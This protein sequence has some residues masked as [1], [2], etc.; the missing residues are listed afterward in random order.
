MARILLIED[1]GGY[2]ST[3][4]E[5]LKKQGYEVK[6][7]Y[8]YN[9]A[10]GLWRKY[11]GVF[12]CIILDLNI[13]PDG[14]EKNQKEEYSPVHGILVLVKICDGKMPNESEES[15]KIWG[16]TIIHSAYTSNLELKLVK[17]A[18]YMSLTRIPK[19]EDSIS[20]V[21][22]KVNEIIINNSNNG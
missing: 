14:L 11:S 21:I 12:D 6:E 15:K 8:S 17:F 19:Q 20:D 10:I 18:P 16:K 4:K 2:A 13:D 7:A 9:S 3:L 5:N 1:N 22:E